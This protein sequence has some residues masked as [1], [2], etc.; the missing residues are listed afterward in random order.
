MDSDKRDILVRG[1]DGYSHWQVPDWTALVSLASLSTDPISLEEFAAA[2]RRYLPHEPLLANGVRTPE[3]LFSA[4]HAGRGWCVIDLVGRTVVA[5]PE[6]ELPRR[7]AAFQNDD[8]NDPAD[9]HIVWF[10]LASDWGWETVTDPTALE[11]TLSTRYELA[12]RLPRNDWREVLMGKPCWD[13]L[14]N[15]MLARPN[16]QALSRTETHAGLVY[17]MELTRSMHREW[18]MTP[19]EDLQARTPRDVLLFDRERLLKDLEHRAEQWTQQR[20]APPALSRDS[21]AYRRGYAGTTEAFLYF[22]LVRNV[23]NEGWKWLLDCPS[24]PSLSD[25]ADFLGR[26]SHLW[27][28]RA[29]HDDDTMSPEEQI[30]LERQRMPR[31][32]QS[33]DGFDDC[34]LCR[35]QA[36]GAFGPTFMWIHEFALDYEE[37]FAFSLYKSYEDWSTNQFE[38]SDEDGDRDGNN[39]VSGRS[40]AAVPPKWFGNSLN[41]AVH[42]RMFEIGQ[43]PLLSLSPDDTSVWE[44]CSLPG[45]DA[46]T[47]PQGTPESRMIALGFPVSEL[48]HDLNLMHDGLDL[49]QE[50]SNQY[51]AFSGATNLQTLDSLTESLRNT[52]ECVAM[53]YPHLLSKSADL[54]CRIDEVLRNSV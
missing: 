26:Q 13:F 16:G 39:V 9:F 20:S 8:G 44:R 53:R 50:L 52:L 23:V 3:W 21:Y 41:S 5:N 4:L 47:G 38:Y 22:H 14:A 24:R 10:D 43:S 2:T 36:E 48:A 49:R 42:S 12:T 51:V 27:L 6:F 25:L 31:L 35:A 15:A 17:E 32:V 40:T 33:H 7:A 54:Q 34:P 45:W 19:R 30:D 1:T 37:D 29:D 18:L 28:G 11:V 46:M